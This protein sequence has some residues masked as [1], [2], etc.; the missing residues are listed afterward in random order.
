LMVGSMRRVFALRHQTGA[1]YSAIEW[2]RARVA[3]CRVVAPAPQPEPASCL[4]SAT[5][6][7][8][9]LRSDSSCRQ[10]VSDLSNVTPR[11]LDS[12]QKGRISLL[13]LTLISHLASLLSRWKAADTVFVLLS[14]SFRV[15][16]YSPSVAIPLLCRITR[17]DK[18]NPSH[19]SGLA[20][21]KAL[22]YVGPQIWCDI[23]E[24]LKSLFTLFIGKT[25]QNSLLSCQYFCWFSFYMLV[26]FCNVVFIASLFPS[27]F[28]L[29]NRSP[30]PPCT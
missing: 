11:Y 5:C 19:T 30:L 14:F 2:T 7:V 1:Q 16:G 22:T 24:K 12:E 10:Y 8:S 20:F 26:T 29:S 6:G 17:Y 15:W 27:S 13:N 9:F 23:P 4:K 25:I 28:Y 18:T 3:V 21:L